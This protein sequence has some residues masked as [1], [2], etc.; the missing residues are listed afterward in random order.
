MA[1]LLAPWILDAMTS[2]APPKPHDE[3]RYAAIAADIANVANAP[4]EEPL[5]EGADGR[6]RTAILLAAF[7]DAESGGYRKDIDSSTR[8]GDGG[9][10]CLMQV[11]VL[12]GHTEEGWTSKEIIA[13]RTLCVRVA[14]HRLRDSMAACHKLTGGDRFGMYTHG[15]CV[16]KN[17]VAG[18]RV[19][20]ASQ[21]Q[22]GHPAPSD[23][24]P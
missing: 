16:P 20:R 6:A 2:W 4:D 9:T 23:G 19:W 13:D 11:K 15:K 5:F 3:P 18:Y 22:K 10:V 21:W 24:G 7:A 8:R 12:G 17:H 1:A 14:L